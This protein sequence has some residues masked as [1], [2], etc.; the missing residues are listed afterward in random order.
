MPN[1]LAHMGIQALVQRGLIRRAEPGWIWLGCLLPDLPWILQ[2]VVM[3]FSL[4]VSP[5]DLRLYAVAQSSLAVCLLAAGGFAL[6]SGAA[7]RVFAILASGSLLHLLLDALQTKWANGVV[8]F[9]PFDW[10]PLNVGLFWPEDW[11]SYALSLLGLVTFLILA[12]REGPAPSRGPKLGAVRLAGA[13]GLLAGY[14]LLPLALGPLAERDD[15]HFAAT[16]RDAAQRPGRSIEFDRAGLRSD[17]HGAPEIAVWTGE[18]LHLTNVRPLP[19]EGDVSLKG[20][21]EDVGTIAVSAYHLHPAGRRDLQT[22]IGL[23]LILWWWLWALARSWRR[24][25]D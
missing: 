1:T 23:G 25:V 21:F 4:D 10:R 24:G 6:L 5:I 3:A 11:P 16:L 15:P 7:M 2:R 12:V 14:M 18:T 22:L 20:R 19:A 13:A 8:L 17:G 9:A